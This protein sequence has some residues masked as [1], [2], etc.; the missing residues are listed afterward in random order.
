VAAEQ[1]KTVQLLVQLT[2]AV[3]VVALV[4]LA[5]LLT[6]HHLVVQTAALVLLFYDILQ[7]LK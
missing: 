7:Q 5:E 2:Q 6:V 4:T 3:V 1:D